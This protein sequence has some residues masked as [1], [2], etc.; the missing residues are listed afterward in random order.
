MIN[1]FHD[2]RLLTSNILWMMLFTYTESSIIKPPVR[3]TLEEVG[4]SIGVLQ[5]SINAVRNTFP[6]GQRFRISGLDWW[7]LSRVEPPE[8]RPFVEVDF[9]VAR[10]D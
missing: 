3:S 5:S 4:V 9:A 2:Y 7:P 10:P 8:L 6:V 1:R